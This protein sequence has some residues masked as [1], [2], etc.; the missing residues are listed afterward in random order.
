VA[1][2]RR[3]LAVRMAIGAGRGRLVRQLLVENVA[4][5]LAGGV[6]GLVL[7]Y[8]GVAAVRHLGRDVL[9]RASEIHPDL[10][11]LVF[12]LGLSVLTGILSGLLPALRA[13]RANP[14]EALQES[15][16]H[17]SASRQ[18]VHVSN[19]LVV[20][21]IGL[22]LLLVTGA[23]LLTRSFVRLLQVS[24]GYDSDH[25]LTASILPMSLKIRQAGNS[26]LPFHEILDRISAIP[27]VEAAAA[28]SQ[29]PLKRDTGT[30]L[31]F[32]LVENTKEIVEGGDSEVFFGV[33][34]DYFHVMG[35]PLLKGRTFTEADAEASRPV[36]VVSRSFVARYWPNQEI[37]GKHIAMSNFKDATKKQ[38]EIVGVV[39]DVKPFALE[40]T[41]GMAEVYMPYEQAPLT[42]NLRTP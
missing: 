38:W 22:A 33:S 24:P 28:T 36:V 34:P 23:G 10:R 17:Q 26:S 32:T 42:V 40:R 14:A 18:R 12:A 13:M 1:N 27:G 16:S 7:A 4:L 41:D 39:A 35:I 9:P 5:G 3:E 21:E 11:V 37:L 25:V 6:A 2:R 31:R 15:G 20:S 8:W 19:L 29:L 30:S